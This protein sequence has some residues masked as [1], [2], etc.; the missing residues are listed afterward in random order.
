[1]LS[2]LAP[3]GGALLVLLCLTDIFLTVLYA[4]GGVGLFAPRL[5]K[6]I[7]DGF[8]AI[9]PDRQ[10]TKDTLL[11]FAGPVI[12]VAT[13]GFW[14]L[15]LVI[16]FALIAWPA[17]GT[18][19]EAGSGPTPS[20]F[21]PALYYSGWS[22]TTLGTG[23]LVPQT[24]LYRALMIV[25][26]VIGFSA[27]TLVL[28]YL[29]SVYS[30]L[31][32]RN[33]LAQQLH[34]LS[35]G[36][37][38][39]AEIVVRLKPGQ[40][41]GSAAVI[42]HQIGTGVLD[43][44]ESHHSYPVLHYFRMRRTRYAMARIALLALDTAA[45]IRAALPDHGGSAEM[46]LGAG[47]DL[48]RDTERTFVGSAISGE[49]ERDWTDRV[50]CALR[51]LDQAGLDVSAFGTATRRYIQVRKEWDGPVRAIARSMSYPWSAIDPATSI[52]PDGVRPHCVGG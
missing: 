8:R 44:L 16:G 18:A 1:M 27:L 36:T 24:D 37:G 47:T 7:W 52:E 17:L 23:D 15:L 32:R 25:E 42:L 38:D 48:V 3:A 40:D 22:L 28:T 19:I 9:A 26:G 20:G 46:L 49:P 29:M 31:V 11:S 14:V 41:G 34:H 13:L 33:A 12:L 6:A 39:A 21:L 2:W 50:G 51:R 30:A 43:L 35:G 4:R 45:L 5:N 10:P